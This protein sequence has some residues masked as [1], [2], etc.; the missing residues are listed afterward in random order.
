MGTMNHTGSQSP[1][2]AEKG[3]LPC[4][5]EDVQGPHPSVG[6]M[7]HIGSQSPEVAVKDQHLSEGVEVQGPHRPVVKVQH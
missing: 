6:I 4:E 2:V 7:N 3:Q 5:G 1:E